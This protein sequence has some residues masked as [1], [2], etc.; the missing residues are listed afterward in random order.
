MVRCDKRYLFA[1]KIAEKI[2]EISE[3]YDILMVFYSRFFEVIVLTI[4]SGA[5]LNFTFVRNIV[6]HWNS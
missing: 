1:W 2:A 5:I 4:I 6:F 3:N